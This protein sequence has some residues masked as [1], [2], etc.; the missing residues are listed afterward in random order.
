MEFFFGTYDNDEDRNLADLKAE[1]DQCHDTFGNLMDTLILKEQGSLRREIH[2]NLGFDRFKEL[3]VKYSDEMT[4]FH[5]SGHHG[6]GATQL[7]DK[8]INDK[9]IARILN[10]S[11]RL[12]IVFLNGCKTE[13]LGRLLID[14]PIVIYTKDNINDYVAKETGVNFYKLLCQDISNFCK[15]AQIK[16]CFEKA[17]GILE[18]EQ[19]IEGEN[20]GLVQKKTNDSDS[21]DYEYIENK[22]VP[23][24]DERMN[25]GLDITNYDVNSAYEKL[26]EEWFDKTDFTTCQI[27]AKERQLYGEF[28]YR[29]FPMP[30]AHFLKKVSPKMDDDEGKKLGVYRFKALQ[31]L[32][33]IKL[34]FLKYCGFSVLW[35]FLLEKEA[36]KNSKAK[37][38]EKDTQ[39]TPLFKEQLNTYLLENWLLYEQ[40]EPA[41]IEERID[42]LLT[43]YKVIEQELK[44]EN[45]FIREGHNFLK[46][47]QK[48]LKKF[49]N[50]FCQKPSKKLGH[51]FIEGESYLKF[52][53]QQ[54]GFFKDY[55]LASVQ[56]SNFTR[57]LIES[58]KYFYTIRFFS[59][60]KRK[61]S[62]KP[63]KSAKIYDVYSIILNHKPNGIDATPV[64]N[65]SP[66]FIDTNAGRKGINEI[67]MVFLSNYSITL[68][69]LLYTSLKDEKLGDPDHWPRKEKDGDVEESKINVYEMVKIYEHIDKLLKI[70]E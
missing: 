20:R 59:K 53:I 29:Y 66:F 18:A 39:L 28:L 57:Y 45:I 41:M 23:N 4:V 56:E 38:I 58:D 43:L 65:L 42:F 68:N 5:F 70:I 26:I 47:N 32:F 37:K 49:A 30:L 17:I 61:K 67:D 7:S 6:D 60:D 35:H 44:I 51:F 16:N 54:A 8:L 19:V 64:L 3:L 24:F 50:T 10:N 25:Y 2:Y 15:P 52:F 55:E 14:V 9:G 12:K 13:S 69:G 33:H 1:Q 48:Q 63:R 11:K 40:G 46:N 36:Q 34:I 62:W 21:S 27:F 31:H 22:D